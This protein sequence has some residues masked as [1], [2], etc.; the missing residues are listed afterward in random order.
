MNR[1]NLLFYATGLCFVFVV[2]IGLSSLFEAMQ[3]T[4]DI[5]SRPKSTV[6]SIPVDSF[7][8]GEVK[9]LKFGNIPYVIWRRD[10][11]QQVEALEQLGVQISENPDLLNQIKTSGEIEIEPGRVLRV[12]WFV[13]SPINVGGY[14]CIVLQNAGD[15]GG[16][17]DPCQ[18]V[19][20]DLWG[21]VKSGPTK[22][23]LKVL[24]WSKSD[25]G[26]TIYVDLANAPEVD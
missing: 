13:V 1:N 20:F 26:T 16:F 15:F 6:R 3:P 12:E 8:R 25:D 4:R 9:V 22:E 14:G 17:F 5:A 19:H 2:I 23:N 21:Q 11:A 18:S 10:F 24:P 7:E